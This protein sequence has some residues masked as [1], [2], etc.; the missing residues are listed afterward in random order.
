M[1][2]YVIVIDADPQ[3]EGAVVSVPINATLH[4]EE[5]WVRVDDEEIGLVKL[6]K[7]GYRAIGP[8]TIA[9]GELCSTREK[10]VSLLVKDWFGPDALPKRK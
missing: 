8:L 2:D 10:A 1:N 3:D 4:V 6:D 7:H 9:P 5:W